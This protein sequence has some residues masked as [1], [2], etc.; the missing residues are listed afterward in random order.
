MG[1]APGRF[2]KAWEF[3]GH[4]HVVAWLF[5]LTHVSAG[6]AIIAALGA[7]YWAY[8]TQ[9]GYLPIA[10]T[11]LGVF[12]A[13]IWGINGIVWLYSRRR[14]SKARITFDYSYGLSLENIIPA[15]DK[16]NIDNTLEFRLVIRNHANGPVKMLVEKLHATVEDRFF[17]TPGQVS[18]TLPRMGNIT[19]FPGG[20]FNKEAFA[21]FKDRTYGTLEYSILYGHPEDP[22]SRKCTKNVALSVFKDVND[23][24]EPT[25]AITWIIKEE[26]DSEI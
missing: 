14:P 21:K 3:V 25:V 1:Q 24:G 23:K 17:D 8:V 6:V 13:G 26:S 22:F 12:V 11:A 18:V 19:I 5:E 16:N 2:R 10:L 15:F 9:W 4:V 7:A 20:G